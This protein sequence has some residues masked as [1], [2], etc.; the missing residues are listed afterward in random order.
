MNSDP[1][2]SVGLPVYN[3]ERYVA[4][5]IEALLG[6]TFTD[7]ELIISDN[8]STDSTSDICREYAK[9]DKRIRFIQQRKNVGLAPNHNIVRDEARGEFFKWA[10]A[11]DLYGR[12]LLQVCVAA[13]DRYPEVLLA[14]AYEGVVDV[15]GRVTQAM[16]Y[17]L[18]TDASRPS[19]RFRSFLFGSSGLFASTDAAHPGIVRVDYDGIL[20]FCDEYGVIRTEAM[21]SVKPLGS[22]HHSDRIVVCELLLRGKFHITPE[23]LYFRRDTTDRSYN[24]S[25]KLRQRCEILDPT[26]KNRLKHPTVRLVGEYVRGYVQA[27]RQAPISADEKRAC[28][29]L[30]TRWVMDRATR[31]VSTAPV[32]SRADLLAEGDHRNEVSARTVVAGWKESSC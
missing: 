22:Y 2:V 24:V 17:P 5:S 19:E 8:A 28:Y 20:S 4:A 18:A 9:S 21:R 13:L 23:W 25:S 7:F 14:H 15:E 16:K 30:L 1:R 6:Q 10:A 32:V 26:R 31:K 27:I 11:D 29:G 12:E 3:S